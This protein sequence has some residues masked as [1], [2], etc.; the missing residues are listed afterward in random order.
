MS[1]I[2]YKTPDGKYEVL[3]GWDRPMQHF[4]LTVFDL[5][6]EPREDEV[7]EAVLYCSMIDRVRCI[8]GFPSSTEVIEKLLTLNIPF[9]RELQ[10]ELKRHGMENLGNVIVRMTLEAA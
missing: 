9:P 4:F 1:Q 2:L 6:R 7:G 5:T 3:T 8:V 10:P